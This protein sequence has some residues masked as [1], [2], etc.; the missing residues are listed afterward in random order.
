MAVISKQAVMQ[1]NSAR[2]K[3]LIVVLG[4]L[5]IS[6]GYFMFRVKPFLHQNDVLNER[7]DFAEKNERENRPL[8][9]GGGNVAAVR[10]KLVDLQT[11]VEQEMS[12]LDGLQ[13]NFIDLSQVDA[14]AIMRNQITDL[15]DREGLRL[16]SI[17]SSDT[18]LEKLAQASAIVASEEL[19]RPLFDI[20]LKGDFNQLRSFIE[21]LKSLPYSVVITKFDLSA[22][23]AEGPQKLPTG[24]LQTLLTVAI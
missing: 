1:K 4:V 11:S 20:L 23:S 13:N 22:A 3:L 24:V 6:G 5:L 16:L 12:T 19:A 14:E 15:V 17:R 7:L 18:S 21:S 8:K 10:K 2:E 9:G